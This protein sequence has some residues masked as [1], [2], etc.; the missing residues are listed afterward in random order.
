[1]E[2]YEVPETSVAYKINR[3]I[4]SSGFKIEDQE[5]LQKPLGF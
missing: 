1:M 2:T 4:I 3:T 5:S